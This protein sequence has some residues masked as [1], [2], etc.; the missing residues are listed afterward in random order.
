M[1]WITVAT[2]RI[3]SPEHDGSSFPETTSCCGRATRTDRRRG[4][5]V[6]HRPSGWRRTDP[7]RGH[8]HVHRR[9]RLHGA[10]SSARRPGVGDLLERHNARVR[11]ELRRFGGRET[12]PPAT[13]SSRPSTPRPRLSSAP[14]RCSGRCAKSD[15]TSVSACTRAS[16][17]SSGKASRP[18]RPYRREGRVQCRRRRGP[19]SQT[20]KDLVAGSGIEFQDRGSHELKGVPGEWRLYSVI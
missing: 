2:S 11:A 12:T 20:V 4:G 8:G 5:G 3:G 9:R 7:C 15:W 18:R 10:S 17:T 13:A 6:P 1:R 16:V 14:G 19:V